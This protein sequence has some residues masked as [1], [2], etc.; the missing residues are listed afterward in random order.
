MD[1]LSGNELEEGRMTYV[2]EWFAPLVRSQGRHVYV[3][4]NC[5]TRNYVT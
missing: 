1:R 3:H 5:G 2:D 4:F